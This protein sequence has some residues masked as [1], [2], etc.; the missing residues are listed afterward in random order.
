MIK[1]FKT[2][3]FTSLLIKKSLLPSFKHFQKTNQTTLN[4]TNYIYK[5]ILFQIINILLTQKLTKI[6]KNINN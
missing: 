2:I 1:H 4:N 6:K 5:Y 3:N